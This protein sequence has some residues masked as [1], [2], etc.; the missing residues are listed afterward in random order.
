MWTELPEIKK[1]KGLEG[2]IL[3][4]PLS[5]DKGKARKM[6]GTAPIDESFYKGKARMI[7]HKNKIIIAVGVSGS[8]DARKFGAIAWKAAES[9]LGPVKFHLVPDF[10][11]GE[12]VL[13]GALLSS[14]QFS[15]YFSE[16]EERPHLVFHG[17]QKAIDRATVNAESVFISRDIT[18]EP[19]NRIHPASLSDRVQ[20]LFKDSDVQVTIQSYDWLKEKG[21]NGVVAVGKGA[22]NKPRLIVMEYSGGKGK[23][24]LIVGKGV[25]FDSGGIHIKPRGH[26]ETMK[27]DV[28]GGAGVIGIMHG[29]AR[30][31]VKQNVV[32]LVP[33][34]EN[35]PS[36]DATR[37]GDVIK[38][39]GGK[40]V[41]VWNTDA[42]GRLIMADAL[43]YGFE[44]FEPEVAL[45]LATLTG[46][47]VV[48]LGNRVAG[49]MGD[50]EIIEELQKAGKDTEEMT[51]EL[52]LF[53]HFS[54]HLESDVADIRNCADKS[55][56]GASVA[57][58]FLENFADGKWVHID[59]AGPGA[60][61][62][63]WLWNSKG[64]TGFGNRMVIKWLESRSQ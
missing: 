58:K 12:K 55:Y 22:T 24:V 33:V 38:M 11:D 40:T 29:L 16:D 59:I 46:A 1:G 35:M 2:R 21:F 39:Y 62:E 7:E 3:A 10:L 13:E 64:G 56:A 52:P 63:P 19:A 43:A 6:V 50:S 57:G 37:P 18:N 8:E 42:E 36:G 28:A 15:R 49:L 51:W 61:K 34:V 27:M 47:C 5:E 60:S 9:F 25:S 53:E 30:L 26:I 4:M 44:K 14:Y 48:A 23:P 41:E 45:D 32:A 20:E 31:N 54:K 17:T